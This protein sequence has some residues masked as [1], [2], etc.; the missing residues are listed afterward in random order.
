MPTPRTELATVATAWDFGPLQVVPHRREV[1]VDGHPLDVGSRAFDLLVALIEARGSLVS[2][3]D[4]IE[5]VWPG[6]VV[7]ENALQAHISALRRAF[8]SQ[9]N[10]IRTVAGRGYQFIGELRAAAPAAHA[11]SGT[12]NL[13]ERMSE[14]I[15][16]DELVNELMALTSQYRLVTLTGPGGVGKTRLA[17][18]VAR[19]LQPQFREGVW[20]AQLGPLCDADLLPAV[21]ASALGLTPAGGTGAIE[22]V[23]AAV[24]SKQALLVLDNCEHVVDAATRMAEGLLG[25]GCSVRIIATSQVPLDAEGEYVCRVPPLD[26]PA[27]TAAD[28]SY[29]T[30]SGAVRLFVARARESAPRFLLDDRLAAKVAGICRRLDGIPLAIELAAK[31]TGALGI[32]ELAARLEDRFGLL[33]GGKR[34]ALPRQQTLRATLDWSHELLAESERVVLRRLAVFAGAFSLSSAIAVASGDDFSESDVVDCVGSLVTKS[35]VEPDTPELH[36]GYR[37]LQTTRDYAFEKLVASGEFALCARRHAEHYNTEFQR[38]EAEW[39]TELTQDWLARYSPCI[40]NV[41]AA[42]DWAFSEVGDAQT[43]VAL[44]VAAVPLWLQLA[45]IDECLGRVECALRAV[46]SGV[47]AGERRVMQLHAA[48][49]WSLMYTTG[50]A[51]E[52]GAAWSAALDLARRLDNADYEMRALWGLWAGHMNNGEFQAALTLAQ[53]FGLVASNSA[54]AADL[55]V[56]ERMLGAALH[57]LG[58]QTAARQRI[59]Y[60]LRHYVL[61][62]RRSHVVRFQF[63]QRVTARMTHARVLWLQGFPDQ[64]MRAVEVAIT[65]AVSLNQSLSTGNTLAQAA[66]PIALLCGDLLAAD[67]FITMFLNHTSRR[68]L[69][70]WHTYGICFRGMLMIKHGDTRQ[71]VQLLRSGVDELRGVNFTQ[72]QTAFLL[73]LAEGYAQTGQVLEAMTAIDEGL[74]RSERFDERWCLPELLRIKGEIELL[75]A[76]GNA[77]A[78]PAEANFIQSLDWAQRQGALSWELRTSTSLAR[79]RH[80]QGSA[81]QAR[82]VLAP[83]LER[84]AEGLETADVVAAR[85]FLSLLS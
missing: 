57:F 17:I 75:S 27:E 35:L 32:D 16:R 49:G 46:A 84:F 38:A 83:V 58:D 23:C 6:R 39:E 41:R 76:N 64:A 62:T 11:R 44:T 15:G 72:Y 25:A 43:G 34:T 14:L 4:L 42:L 5:R 37:L 19:H 53:R 69:G 55:L 7:E 73:N 50:T 20:V 21:V 31:R 47:V 28:V 70:V 22:R 74:E 60:V 68:A 67:R 12:T 79:L 54:D 1:F 33:T 56:G 29:A 52:T 78:A 65:E 81:V 30:Q 40:A 24:G 26:V 3:D 48:H 63:D 10:L 71:G 80:A 82:A 13:P 59:E 18:E 9:R 51:R 36:A 2:K 45:L 8:G 85:E 66:C 61:P 77:N